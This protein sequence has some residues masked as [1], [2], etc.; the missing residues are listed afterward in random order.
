MDEQQIDDNG[1]SGQEL[2]LP[3]VKLSTYRI[4]CLICTIFGIIVGWNLKELFT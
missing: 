3:T 2:E 1:D 4:G